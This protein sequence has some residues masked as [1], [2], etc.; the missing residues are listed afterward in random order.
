LQEKKDT[1]FSV[2]SV[3]KGSEKIGIATILAADGGRTVEF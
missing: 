2:S 3:K 1:K